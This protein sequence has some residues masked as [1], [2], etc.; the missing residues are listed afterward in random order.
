MKKDELLNFITSKPQKDVIPVCDADA[1]DIV[2]LN[3][4]NNAVMALITNNNKKYIRI[5]PLA[6]S[7]F[8]QEIDSTDIVV[9]ASQMPNELTSLIEWWNDRPVLRNQIDYVFGKLDKNIFSKVLRLIEEQPLIEKP[10]KS[11]VLFRESEKA[12][13]NVVSADFY[14]TY[15]LTYIMGEII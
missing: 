9:K 7:P 8:Q 14:E 13:G 1:G 3:C 11:V 12:K 15:N 5:S 2:R 10:S 6:I 4:G